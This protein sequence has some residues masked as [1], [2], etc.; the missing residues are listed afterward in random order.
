[1][2]SNNYKY[3]ITLDVIEMSKFN[4]GMKI[5]EAMVIWIKHPA[6][7]CLY[8]LSLS[9]YHV[10]DMLE[11]INAV[12]TVKHACIASIDKELTLHINSFDTNPEK[13]FF[14]E[15]LPFVVN[16]EIVNLNF[17]NPRFIFNREMNGSVDFRDIQIAHDAAIV[18]KEFVEEIFNNFREFSDWRIE[19]ISDDDYDLM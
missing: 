16:I 19:K 17:S 6:D 12:L 7:G 11:M 15:N 9:Y 1:M 18:Y 8:S 3:P 14:K 13:Q 4:N 5:P 2:I 10:R